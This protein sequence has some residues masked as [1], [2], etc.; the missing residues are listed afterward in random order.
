MFLITA[1]AGD[2]A[3]RKNN[4]RLMAAIE[5]NLV[6]LEAEGVIVVERSKAVVVLTTTTTP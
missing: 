2:K 4:S 1:A 6:T 3:R 5:A